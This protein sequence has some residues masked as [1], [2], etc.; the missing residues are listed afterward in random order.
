[1]RIV[2]ST[3]PGWGHVAPLLPLVEELGR[4]GHDLC[5]VTAA[6]AA[7]GLRARGL[8]TVEGGLTLVERLPRARVELARRAPTPATLRAEAYTVHFAML[9]APAALPGLRRAVHDHR[10]DLIVREPA[11]LASAIVAEEAGIPTVTVGFGGIVP[12]AARQ[13]ADELLGALRD[14]AASAD[15][16]PLHFGSLYLHPMPP[17]MDEGPLPAVARRVRP[18]EDVDP[19]RQL[20]TWIDDLGAHRPALYVTFGTEF[21]GL[22]P[23][24]V[25]LDA[26]GGLD[27]DAVVTTGRAGLPEHTTVPANTRVA[28]YVPQASLMRRVHAVVSHGGSGTLLGAAA[29]ARPQLAIPL[30]ADQFDNAMALR[31]SG[32]GVVASTDDCTVAGLRMLIEQLLNDH[33]VSAAA[34]RVAAEMAAAATTVE[35][36]DWVEAS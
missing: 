9:A 24:P 30:G 21:G 31:R 15:T 27:L 6:D 17:A 12:A 3:T 1:V 2:V 10:A 20:R 5:W 29:A 34:E 35:A 33:A 8:P 4:R 22:A 28:T 16:D 19:D 13:A 25:V 36:A 14:P 23:W 32:A 18:S 26:I 7:S 11:E